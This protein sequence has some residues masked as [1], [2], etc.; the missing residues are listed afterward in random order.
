MRIR[1]SLVFSSR[2]FAVGLLL[3]VNGCKKTQSEVSDIRLGKDFVIEDEFVSKATAGLIEGAL[4]GGCVDFKFSVEDEKRCT[5]AF[6]RLVQLL[7]F[8]AATSGAESGF[9]FLHAELVKNVNSEIG[10]G[11]LKALSDKISETLVSGEKLPLWNVSLAYFKGDER[12]TIAHLA[13]LFQDTISTR[14]QLSWLRNTGEG[15]PTILEQVLYDLDYITKKGLVSLYPPGVESEREALYHFYIPLYFSSQMKFDWT[16][17]DMA[18]LTAFLFNARYEF[19]QI[20]ENLHPEDKVNY[21]VEGGFARRKALLEDLLVHLKGKLIP[22]DVSK[23]A[24][25]F[26]DL[27]LGFA[28]GTLGAGRTDVQNL[29]SSFRKSFALDP[30]GFVAKMR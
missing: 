27:Y 13:S 7:D 8:R 18:F 16:K 25:N 6:G 28:G 12:Q 15:D 3:A 10:K 20:W 21:K 11:Y 14:A 26:E 5:A 1:E 2:I 24:G 22:F 4:A 29:L 19:R 23:E 9:V 17:R 30:M